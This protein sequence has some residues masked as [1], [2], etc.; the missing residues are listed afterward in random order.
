MTSRGLARMGAI[1]A[2]ACTLMAPHCPGS[3][4]TGSTTSST[5]STPAPEKKLP[6]LGGGG[7]SD[8]GLLGGMK[9]T[10]AEPDAGSSSS[11]VSPPSFQW[12]NRS[13]GVAGRHHP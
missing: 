4:S 1:A 5:S 8:G 9:S 7:K 6:N 13:P 2:L 12:N 3:Q 10:R 11:H